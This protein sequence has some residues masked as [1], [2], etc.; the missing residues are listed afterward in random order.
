MPSEGGVPSGG[1]QRVWCPVKRVG[2]LMGACRGVGCPVGG[3]IGCP[4][5]ACRGMECPVGLAKGLSTN[6]GELIMA[7][8]HA[9]FPQVAFL[10]TFTG[11]QG[12]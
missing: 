1:L 2:C 10:E 3:C 8:K 11:L 7:I 4:V 5:M 9:V 6:E 12:T